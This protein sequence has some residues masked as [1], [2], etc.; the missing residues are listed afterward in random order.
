MFPFDSPVSC[1]MIRGRK[2]DF[3]IKGAEE[4]L[5]EVADEGV[6]VV[7]DGYG[8]KAIVTDPGE[9]GPADLVRGVPFQGITFRPS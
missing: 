6:A 8:R 1:R 7:T 3:D 9:E 5:E 2:I 4:V